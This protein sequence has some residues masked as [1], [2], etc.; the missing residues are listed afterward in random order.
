[1]SIAVGIVV[2]VVIVFAKTLFLGTA[3]SKVHVIAEWDSIFKNYAVGKSQLMDPSLILLMVPYYLMV[4]RIWHSGEI[5]LW[6]LQSGF[7]APLL[8]DPQALAFSILHLPMALHPT[9]ATY[10]V[11]LVLELAILAVGGF[12]LGRCLGLTRFPSAFLG[13]TLLFCPF[14]QWY[15]ELLGNGYC[16]IPFLLAAFLNAARHLSIMSAI[17]AGIAASVMVL[18]AHPELSFCSI[19]IASILMITMSPLS[20]WRQ[21]SLMLTIAGAVAFCLSAPMLLPFLEFLAN[22]DS[23]KFGNR[24]PAY[25]P[26]QT[27]AFNM[28]QP[29]YGGASPYF[30]ALAALAFPFSIVTV[31]DALSR[32]NRNGSK[33]ADGENPAPAQEFASRN[34]WALRASV[35]V[36]ALGLLAWA[37]SAKVY[38]LGML[39]TRRPFSYVV[40]TYFF[41]VLLVLV[42]ALAAFGLERLLWLVMNKIEGFEIPR[43]RYRRIPGEMFLIAFSIIAIS[44]FP[45]LMRIANVDPSIANF[46]MT[47]PSME[48]A[49]RDWVRNSLIAGSVGTLMFVLSLF[50][51]SLKRA[52]AIVSLFM[53]AALCSQLAISK[54]SLPKR[55]PFAYP[56]T[57]TL[58]KL[59]SLPDRRLIFTGDHTLRPN[60]NLAYNIRDARFHNPIFPRYYLKFLERAG[61][62]LDEFNQ[63]FSNS[64]SR[65]LNAASVAYVI[66][67]DIGLDSS[68]DVVDEAASPSDNQSRRFKLIAETG[69]GMHIYENRHAVPDA[70]IVGKTREVETDDQALDALSEPEFDPLS[71]V[72][73]QIRKEDEAAFRA[74]L[75]GRSSTGDPTAK[76]AGT[77]ILAN[78]EGT[79]VSILTESNAPGLLVLTDIWYPGWEATVDGAR[80]TIVRANY[81]FRAIALPAGKHS[82]E[83]NYRPKPFY[84]GCGLALLAWLSIVAAATFMRKTKN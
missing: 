54:A 57:E 40:V 52:S 7:G 21:S 14:E 30:G 50:K 75:T 13:V 27:L 16:L 19:S 60:T 25:Y 43:D 23:Y 78:R 29:G 45:A 48:I 64:P 51:L 3:I 72:V 59:Q 39:L 35:V 70:Y 8:A 26:W 73:L 5:P 80:A 76:M 1:V 62:K 37:V 61:A 83:F 63:V 79:N 56:Q 15:L 58:K 66:T 49:T 2:L 68:S 41:P 82:V 12:V 38:P 28:L 71:E 32:R 42:A 67:T 10:N 84:I 9:I 17:V 69:E 77:A 44:A 6:N 36:A 18:S 24:A 11:T 34:R 33:T 4:G 47:L 55:P 81:S 20:K 65:L 22:S 31:Y 46:D 53:V 74:E